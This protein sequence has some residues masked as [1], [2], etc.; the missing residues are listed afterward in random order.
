MARVLVLSNVR[1]LCSYFLARSLRV[2]VPGVVAQA[3]T[4]LQILQFITS[5]T[6]LCHGHYQVVVNGRRVGDAQRAHTGAHCDWPVK[7][8][9]IALLMNVSYLYLFAQFFY[10]AYVRGHHR[11]HTKTTKAE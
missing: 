9:T 5:A 11:M 1:A 3:V 2:S 7:L 6:L 8:A 4:G 10:N